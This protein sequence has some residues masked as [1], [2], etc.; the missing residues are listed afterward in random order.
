MEALTFTRGRDE[1]A[2]LIRRRPEK[3]APRLT[4]AKMTRCEGVVATNV[5]PTFADAGPND[6]EFSGE[7]KRGILLRF[8]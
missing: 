7:R 6:I 2:M 4:R 8:S 3:S 5:P 1:G